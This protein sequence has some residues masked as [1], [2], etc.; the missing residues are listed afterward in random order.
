MCVGGGGGGAAYV[1]IMMCFN[2]GAITQPLCTVLKMGSK[3]QC[4]VLHCCVSDSVVHDA[5]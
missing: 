2:K 1:C 4:I 5:V 3:A